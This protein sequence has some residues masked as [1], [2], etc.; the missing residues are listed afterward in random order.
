VHDAFLARVR[1]TS[2]EWDG[3]LVFAGFSAAAIWGLPIVGAIPQ[4]IDVASAPAPGGRSNSALRRSYLPDSSVFERVDGLR[5]T[6]LERTVVDAARWGTFSQ[7]VVICDS[8]LGPVIHDADGVLRS[9]VSRGDLHELCTRMGPIP[10]K[11]KAMAVV[12]FADGQSASPGES[13]SRV[14][15]SSLG[16]PAPILQQPFHD[17]DG[18]IGYV[19]FW[20]P[21]FNLIGEFDGRG[22]YLRD[23]YTAGKSSA[24]IVI[25]EKRRED[26]LRSTSTHPGVVRWGWSTVHTPGGLRRVLMGAGLAPSARR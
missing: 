12:A 13:L 17:L 18:L 15:I 8:V 3:E 20:W 19:D 22:K 5:V 9:P 6:P 14:A 26:R 24:E 1:A 4:R 10:G 23:E 16:F 25:L 11:R 2:L 21:A 7:G